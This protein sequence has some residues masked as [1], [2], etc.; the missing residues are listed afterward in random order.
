M[1]NGMKVCVKLVPKMPCSFA[2]NKPRKYLGRISGLK[3]RQ[4]ELI[5]LL[6]KQK[7]RRNNTGITI[8][9]GGISR[10]NLR[11]NEMKKMISFESKFNLLTSK[12]IIGIGKHL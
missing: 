4:K 6:P 11:F 5:L 2:T 8:D 9:N 1:N 12:A 7:L 10:R 3:P